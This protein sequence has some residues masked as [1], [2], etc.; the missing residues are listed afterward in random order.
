MKKYNKWAVFAGCIALLSSGCSS[1]AAVTD[2]RAVTF[3]DLDSFYRAADP[4]GIR[5]IKEDSTSAKEKDEVQTLLDA[6]TATGAYGAVYIHRTIDAAGAP[7]Q[8]QIV[9]QG[10]GQN[11]SMIVLDSQK[12]AEDAAADYTCHISSLSSVSRKDVLYHAAENPDNGNM[13]VSS[14]AYSTLTINTTHL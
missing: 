10:T 12:N 1:P 4:G 3:L 9:L 11:L 8:D 5:S 2:Q 14:P 6:I 7:A 13:H